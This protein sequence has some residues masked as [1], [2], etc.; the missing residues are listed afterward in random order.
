VCRGITLSEDM[1]S[2]VR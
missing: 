1:I 2:T